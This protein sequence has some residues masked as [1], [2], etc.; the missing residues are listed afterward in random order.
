MSDRQ[1][2][3]D[4]LNQMHQFP[5]AMMIKVIG[6]N[7]PTFVARVVAAVRVEIV[8]EM[9]PPYSVRETPNGRHVAITLEPTLRDAEQVLAVY[10]VLRK[11][12]GVV[13]LM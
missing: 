11:V 6:A 9:D 3:L 7:H 1:Q 12:E 5:T 2:S 10:E 13:M 4:L 8:L